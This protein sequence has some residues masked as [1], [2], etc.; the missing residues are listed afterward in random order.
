MPMLM[1][2][3][4]I[5]QVANDCIICS[6]FKVYER[7]MQVCSCSH[8]LLLTWRY[9]KKMHIVFWKTTDYIHRGRQPV[10]QAGGASRMLAMLQTLKLKEELQ[11][12]LEF[13][14]CHWSQNEAPC[15]LP[16][17]FASFFLKRIISGNHNQPWISFL[18]SQERLF[19][20]CPE[21]CV[22]IILSVSMSV[23]VCVLE[24]QHRQWDL[25]GK[26]QGCRQGQMKNRLRVLQGTNSVWNTYT[27]G[28]NTGETN[29]LITTIVSGAEPLLRGAENWELSCLVSREVSA[30]SS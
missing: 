25:W 14:L 21:G 15:S 17:G 5:L 16:Q 22:V 3:L 11:G 10:S 30:I 19:S 4:S 13:N 1:L 27:P 9:Q 18:S 26:N 29:Q 12:A 24:S 2:V 7:D 20:P 8:R 23:F 6:S 28:G